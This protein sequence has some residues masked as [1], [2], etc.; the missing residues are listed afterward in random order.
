MMWC[1]NC[2]RA[3]NGITANYQDEIGYMFTI[4]EC[5]FCGREVYREA[6]EC[7]VCGEHIS[8]SKSLCDCCSDE[9]S[10]FVETLAEAKKTTKE[11]VLKGMEEYLDE[12][13]G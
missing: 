9:I 10:S 13:E 3:V 1:D 2:K 8:P 4:Q 12:R 7:A 5:E 6:N 11:A